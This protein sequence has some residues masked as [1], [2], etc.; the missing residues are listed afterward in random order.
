MRG[1]GLSYAAAGVDVDAYER[2]LERVRPLI[3][4]THGTEVVSGI[5]PFAGLY[6]LPGGGR[7]A[8][9]ADS[10]GTKVKVAVACGR[11]RGI[12]HDIVNHCVNDVATTGARPLFFLDYFA[13]ARLDQ[14]VFSEVVRG[15]TEAC[16]AN[17]CALLGGET[18]EM[19]GVYETGAYD[20][21]GFVIGHVDP[22]VTRDPVRAGDLLIGLPSSGLHTNGFSLA[23]KVFEDVPVDHVFP[24]LGRPLGEVL[25]EPHRSYLRDLQ[26]LPWKAAAH[27][28]GGGLLGNVQ[29]ALPQGL[30]AE[31]ERS[32]WSVPTIFE[33]IA[34]R[35]RIADDEMLGTFNVGLGMVLV[36]DGPLPGLPVVGRVLEQTESRRVS[37]R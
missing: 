13:S 24:E 26:T 20:V 4:A 11:H 5:G 34:R 33:L 31:L 15:L 10:V 18:A 35:G 30:A 7:L 21:V 23:R 3:S 2:M 6:E 37:V 32:A 1:A 8:A 19:P 36:A 25:L 12:G 9:S 27:I 14:A 16:N 17:G 22:G 28:T 29:R